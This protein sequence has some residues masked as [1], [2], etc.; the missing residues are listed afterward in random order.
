[1]RLPRFISRLI[2]PLAFLLTPATTVAANDS[3][4]RYVMVAMPPPDINSISINEARS[5]F[6]MR[7]YRWPD[8]SP[9]T[10]F[11]LPDDSH[12]HQT[13][14]RNQLG[15]LPRQLKRNWERMVYT[16]IGKAPQV[17]ANE[18]QMLKELLATPGAVGYV[19][20]DV[21]DGKGAQLHAIT[22]Q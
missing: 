1:M 16:G 8:G 11:V 6:S 4:S 15:L 2:L 12:A 10:V 5:I 17:V 18:E 22:L 3:A 19:N 21:L 13:F 14:I 7:V 20:A 9:I